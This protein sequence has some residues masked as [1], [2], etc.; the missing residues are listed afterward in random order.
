[1][2]VAAN[3]K[4]RNSK[5]RIGRKVCLCLFACTGNSGWK[6]TLSRSSAGSRPCDRVKWFHSTNDRLETARNFI[7][8]ESWDTAKRFHLAYK[9][10]FEDDVQML[11]RNMTSS[12][13]SYIM[14]QLPNTRNIMVWYQILQR[15]IP[16]NWEET[17]HYEGLGFF[18]GNYLGIRSY[19]PKLRGPEMRQRC[20]PFALESGVVY[21]YD[22]YSC[23]SLLNADELNPISTRLQTPE[24]CKLF[25]CFLQWPFQIIFLDVANDF[26]SHISEDIFYNLV[27]F[28][29]RSKLGSGFQDHMY[30]EIFKPFWNLFSGD[31]QY[32]NRIKKDVKLYN[33][34]RCVL[35]R[36]N[37][38]DVGKYQD[39][40][41]LYFSN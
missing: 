29:L 18:L 21:H 24:F 39:L 28:I 33:L 16:L 14:L 3:H 13:G 17:S 32:E 26:K 10:F 2:A 27:T 25:K 9:Y 41:N 8:D 11:W 5:D 38:Y 40:L 15:S 23:I 37:D 20:I 4:S 34:A 12:E 30:I 36:S 31:I 1:M 6:K 7:H 19:F 22:L 35:E